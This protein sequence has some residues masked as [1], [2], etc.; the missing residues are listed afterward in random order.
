MATSSIQAVI[1]VIAWPVRLDRMKI[2]STNIAVTADLQP[3]CE[4]QCV[5]TTQDKVFQHCDSLYSCW[6]HNDGTVITTTAD[7]DTPL[8]SKATE[9]AVNFSGNL[10]NMIKCV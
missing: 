2:S 9:W 1:N 8:D 5:G 7:A 3:K 6:R 4:K 10:I